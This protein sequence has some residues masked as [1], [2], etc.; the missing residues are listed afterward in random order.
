MG[1]AVEVDEDEEVRKRIASGE[2]VPHPKGDPPVRDHIVAQLRARM[3]APRPPLA[4][5]AAG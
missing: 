5:K 3:S 4:K 2:L 1:V